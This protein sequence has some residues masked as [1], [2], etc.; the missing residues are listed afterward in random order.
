MSEPGITPEEMAAVEAKHKKAAAGPK[1]GPKAGKAKAVVANVGELSPASRKEVTE[2]RGVT[3]VDGR[4][5]T[6]EVVHF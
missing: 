5:V 2:E 1:S 4:D 6:F 3:T